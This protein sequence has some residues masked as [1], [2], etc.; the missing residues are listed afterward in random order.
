MLRV[1]CK[2]VRYPAKVQKDP[3]MGTK[4]AISPKESMVMNTIAP[5]IA[6][7]ISID[8]GPPVASDLP[9]PRKSPVPIVPPIAIIEQTAFEPIC[10]RQ[11]LCR[12]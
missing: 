9:V 7:P 12:R 11:Q 6:Y 5:T 8:A 2:V 3:A 10:L 4:A 1:K